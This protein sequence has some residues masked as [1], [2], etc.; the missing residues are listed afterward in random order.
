M[1]PLPGRF[2]LVLDH[3]SADR[4]QPGTGTSSPRSLRRAAPR[5]QLFEFMAGTRAA[6][7]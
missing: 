6:T 3:L 2:L 4:R 5:Q 1:H 7:G